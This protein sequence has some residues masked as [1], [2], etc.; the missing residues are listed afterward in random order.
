MQA[1]TDLENCNIV[2]PINGITGAYLMD[3]GNVVG[4]MSVNK[5]LVAVENV[6]QLYVEFSIS[7]NDFYDLQ[8]FSNLENGRLKVEVSS[9]SDEGIKGETYVDFI[10]NS[11]D[12]KT[13]SIKLRASME[14]LEHKFWPGQSVRTKL[15]LTIVKNSILVPPEA[16]KLG[17]QGIYIFVIKK[18]KPS[19]FDWL[20]LAK[21][22]VTCW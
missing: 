20:K 22:K 8:M 4:A 15:L 9:I 16:V 10:N 2:S 7:E 1:K 6:D 18:D 19:S 3:A 11:I 17:Q 5:P 13:G 12:K 14:N 21:S